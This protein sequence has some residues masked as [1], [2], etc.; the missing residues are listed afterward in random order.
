MTD[1]DALA[2]AFLD[3]TEWKGAKAAPLA[4]DASNRR[5]LRIHR[6]TE[7]AV[8]MDAPRERGEDVRPFVAIANYLSGIGLS[9]PRILAQ[10]IDGG[11][12]LIE[13]LG[14]DL[15]ARI[16]PKIPQI[17]PALYQTATDV[18]ITLHGRKPPAGLAAYDTALMTQMAALALEWY[19]GRT[20]PALTSQFC[21]AMS[22]AIDTHV[23]AGEV[24]IQRDYHAENLLWLPDRAGPARVGLLDFQDAMSGH[25]A[26][27]LVSLLQDARRDVPA[28][29]AAR[30]IEYYVDR[31]G[32]DRA[33]F[34]AAYHVLGAQRNLRILG[35]FAR[36]CMRDGKAHYVD[37]IP[38]VWAHLMH[39]LDHPALA[40]AAPLIRGALPE[41]TRQLLE[42]MKNRC[43]TLQT[44]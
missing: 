24:L 17:E 25:R 5:Y 31:T 22:A 26:Y 14:D 39:D 43:Q 13:D 38:R 42:E 23:G 9:A 18:L 7:T 16:I 30:M 32:Q 19:A 21:D 15:F 36:L 8:L 20:D 10:D 2:M 34:D 11:F 41:P 4:G 44:P 35:V 29:L 12:L 37:L 6:G 40:D 1:R 27:D 28:P 3:R 33:A